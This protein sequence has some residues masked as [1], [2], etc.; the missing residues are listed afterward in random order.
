M[1]TKIN[2]ALVGFGKFGKKYYKNILEDNRF[3]LKVIFRK[4]IKNFDKTNKKFSLKEIKKNNIQA[5]IICTP[6]NTHYRLSKIFIENKIPIILEKPASTNFNNIKKLLKLAQKKKSS[7]IVNHSDLHNKNF[8]LILA[9]KR[10]IGQI[11]FIK[12]HFGKY[13][14]NYSK[15]KNPFNDWIPHPLSLVITLLNNIKKF[16][17]K[18]VANSVK[19]KGS[20]IFQFSHIKLNFDKQINCEVTIWNTLKKKQRQLVVYGRNGFI[21]YDGYNSSNNFINL[22]RKKIKIQSKI[23]PMENIL[24]RL[25]KTVSTKRFISD[26]PLALKIEAINSKIRF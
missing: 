9:K 1:D 21:N 13:N 24:T 3:E 2:L 17:I 19:K 8:E 25:Y 10:L 18:S 14:N 4:Q 11:N 23:T 16:K 6:V 5:A 15:D 7:V 22:K 26:L 12:C 20:K